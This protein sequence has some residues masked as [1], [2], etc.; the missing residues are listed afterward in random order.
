MS[1]V[2]NMHKEVLA[3]DRQLVSEGTLTGNGCGDVDNE[4]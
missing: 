2:V 1:R 4:A 3:A